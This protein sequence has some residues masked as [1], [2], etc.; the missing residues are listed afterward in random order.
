MP[1]PP[2]AAAATLGNFRNLHK[3]KMVAADLGSN[4]KSAITFDRIKLEG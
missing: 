2:L 3:S 1:E 4:R